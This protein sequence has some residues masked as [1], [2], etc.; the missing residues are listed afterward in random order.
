MRCSTAAWWRTA[1]TKAC[2]GR[3]DLPDAILLDMGLPDRPGLLVL[4]QLKENPL[5]RHIPV[6]I[7]SG[8]DQMQG[9]AAGRH[10][11]RHQAATREQLKE[12]F[13]R[14]KPSSRRR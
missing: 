9:H 10:R 1:P 14:S 4:Q 2:A 11:L 8:N 3:R 5:T 7:V 6:H 13:R 12:V